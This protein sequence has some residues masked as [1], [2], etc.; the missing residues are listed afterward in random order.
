MQRRYTINMQR[1]RKVF[2]SFVMPFS[3]LHVVLKPFRYVCDTV[4]KVPERRQQKFREISGVEIVLTHIRRTTGK[5]YL[6]KHGMVLLLIVFWCTVV[7]ASVMNFLLDTAM[8]PM[9]AHWLRSYYAWAVLLLSIECACEIACLPGDESF[10]DNRNTSHCLVGGVHRMR[11]PMTPPPSPYRLLYQQTCEEEDHVCV[12]QAAN[13]YILYPY[14]I[15]VSQMNGVGL[16]SRGSVA[17]SRKSCDV[18]VGVVSVQVSA[19]LSASATASP[20]TTTRVRNGW[21]PHA[22]TRSHRVTQHT[23]ARA[24]ASTY[25]PNRQPKSGKGHSARARACGCVISQHGSGAGSAHR[26]GQVLHPTP[27]AE[28]DGAISACCRRALGHWIALV[29]GLGRVH[30]RATVDTQPVV[31]V[32]VGDAIPLPHAVA[33]LVARRE[34]CHKPT[35][36]D[37]RFIGV[38]CIN[39]ADGGW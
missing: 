33:V 10:E 26:E 5:T 25:I 24:S 11:A 20:C 28:Q 12:L 37:T 38:G 34:A 8:T 18:A 27:E 21:S 3:V 9:E 13:I 6:S 19:S 31:A 17:R 22:Y 36:F 15:R 16:S 29:A 39:S 30:L 4:R 32:G 35:S 14:G 1:A 7:Y 23:H 2:L